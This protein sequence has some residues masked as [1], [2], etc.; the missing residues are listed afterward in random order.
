[1]QMSMQGG[2]LSAERA[3]RIVVIQQISQA[4]LYRAMRVFGA[5]ETVAAAVAAGLVTVAV[6]VA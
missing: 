4:D 3:G 6:R 1:M 2:A 5:G